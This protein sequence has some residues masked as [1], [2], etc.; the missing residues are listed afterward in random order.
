MY[1]YILP[2]KDS[3]VGLEDGGEEGVTEEV[4]VGTMDGA[5]V[6]ETVEGVWVGAAV[7]ADDDEITVG[8]VVLGLTEGAVEG[9]KEGGREGLY[10]GPQLGSRD[11]LEDGR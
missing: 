9:F 4:L 3:M 5:L 10:E 1:V 2:F 11:G 8:P 6:L 7:G